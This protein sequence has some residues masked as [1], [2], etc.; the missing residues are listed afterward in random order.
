M[1][2]QLSVRFFHITLKFEFLILGEQNW[3]FLDVKY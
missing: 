2:I 3:K 1:F